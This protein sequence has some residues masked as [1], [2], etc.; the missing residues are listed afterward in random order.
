MRKVGSRGA[1]VALAV[2]AA[3]LLA[4]TGAAL[5]CL[6]DSD[7]LRVE[8]KGLPD[9]VRAIT[10]RFER[11]PPRY[12]EM[13]LARVA[14]RLESEPDDLP[15]YD[16]AAVACDRLGRDD[17]AIAWMAKK[18]ARLDAWRGGEP[19]LANEHRYRTLANLGTFHAHRWFKS[20]ADR[21]NL[22]DLKTGRDRIAEAIALNPNA[23]FGREG[24][25][26]KILDAVLA[27][28][29]AEASGSD[30]PLFLNPGETG[31]KAAAAVR[32]LSA[33]VMLGNAWESVDVYNS[34]S[35]A[36]VADGRRSSSAWLAR[37]RAEE[38]VDAGKGSFVAGAPTGEALKGR[39]FTP[40]G[41]PVSKE[42]LARLYR[43]LRDEAD[44]WH[45]AR[46]EFMYARLSQGKHPD[47]DADFWADYHDPGPPA[48][49][50]DE[51]LALG[52]GRRPVP[53]TA[54]SGLASIARVWAVALV[55]LALVV[56][57]ARRLDGRSLKVWRRVASSRPP[58]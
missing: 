35:A 8:T 18:Q 23:H 15:L 55:A 5:A 24:Y 40:P 21:A 17:E 58:L 46:V 16:D 4:G 42:A 10:G 7:T 25:Q 2:G 32:A 11:N 33:L 45:K 12:Y 54:R 57:A 52:V 29:P 44:A 9:V 38:L 49:D 27:D 28:R 50:E 51:S 31:E 20:G 1:V 19:L 36:L 47:T 56:W 53:T 48:L 14:D 41:V 6:W 26:L 22:D 13:R 37:W 43:K 30:L 34:L 3:A 39:L